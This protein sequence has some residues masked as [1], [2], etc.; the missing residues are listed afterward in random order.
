M[1]NFVIATVFAG[2]SGAAAANTIELEAT[3]NSNVAFE[4]A[5]VTIA[6]NQ[7]VFASSVVTYYGPRVWVNGR[8][9]Q[10]FVGP[11]N[12]NQFCEERGHNQEVSGSTITCGEDESSYANYDWYGKSWVYK[13]TGSKNQCYQLYATIKC[14]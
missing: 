8:L 13:S 5:E 14:Q 3:E 7:G 4:K 6:P 12:G 1:K 2:L 9:Q 11:T 10:F